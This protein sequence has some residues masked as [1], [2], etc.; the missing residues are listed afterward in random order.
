MTRTILGIFESREN[1]EN[2]ISSLREKGFD[3]K[4]LS[5]VMR[6]QQEAEKIGEDTGVDVAGGAVSGATTG[7]VL[8]GLA[9]LLAASVIPGLGAFFIGGPIAS[10]LGLTGAAAATVSGATTGAVAGGLL[11]ALMGFGLSEDEARHYESRVKEGAILLAVPVEETEEPYVQKVFEEFGASDVK[12]ITSTETMHQNTRTKQYADMAEPEAIE[13]QQFT[14]RQSMSAM[15]AKG[16]KAAE[17][18]TGS[19]SKTVRRSKKA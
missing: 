17:K 2:A 10:A 16:G 8:G 5:I 1:I 7:A 15:G 9:G 3:P 13:E 12:T 6:D 19:K 14:Q 11:G 4:D 18:K